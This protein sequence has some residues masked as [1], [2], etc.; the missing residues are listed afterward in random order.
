MK[1]ILIFFL[2][3]LILVPAY[4]QEDTLDVSRKDALNIFLDC[5]FCDQ[6]H[7]KREIPYVNY[8]RDRK[9]GQVHVMVTSQS[10]G[11]GGREYT[12]HFLGQLDFAG[13]NDTLTFTSNTDNTNE[14][15]REGQVR[16]LKLGLMQYVSKTPLAQHINISYALPIE[17]EVKEDKWNSWV[18]RARI[19]GYAN[20]QK[21]YSSW[22]MDGSFSASRVTPEWKMDFD[23]DYNRS[24]N[25]YETS[26]GTLVDDRHSEYFDALVVKSLTDHW[27]AGGSVD[28]FSSTYSNYDLSIQFRPGIEYNIFPYSE[29]TRKQLR[30]LYRP[31]LEFNNYTDTTVYNK[32]QETLVSQRL[33]IAYEVIQKWGSVN[34]SLGWKNYFHNWN[35]NN[36][37]FFTSLNIRIVKGL[38]FNLGGGASLIHDQINL[39]KGGATDEEILLK[40]RELET[41][42]RYFFHMG[43]SYTF[44]SIYNNVVNPRFGGS[45]GYYI[46]Y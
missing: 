38:R 18:F 22:D 17:E 21:S 11:S 10:A 19:G 24:H 35:I 23:I 41:N 3:F 46:I 43:L 1:A 7:I 32:T 37:N 14:E 40:R 39:P 2:P 8:V 44:G 26:E 31:G 20:S 9:E 4:G 16:I 28:I 12:F 25:S 6:S 30:I 33:D 13:I 15:I 42:Y 34:I 36:L 27:S 45:G 29:S 5:M